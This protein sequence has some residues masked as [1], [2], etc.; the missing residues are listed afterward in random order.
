ML[1]RF[2][3]HFVQRK[4]QVG[5]SRTIGAMPVKEEMNSYTDRKK[6]V[7]KPK[8]GIPNQVYANHKYGP[9]PAFVELIQVQ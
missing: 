4:K 2:K 6:G 5:Q 7:S 8:G 9:P 1:H 3:K